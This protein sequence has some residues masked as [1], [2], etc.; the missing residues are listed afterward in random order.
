MWQEMLAL[1]RYMSYYELLT[2]RYSF[3]NR[4]VR[5]FLVAGATLAVGSAI[6]S[7]HWLVGVSGAVL[8]VAATTV[9]LVWDW[10]TRAALAHAISLECAVIS[11]DY[12]HLWS[13]VET[14]R[15]DEDTCH[16]RIHQLSMRAIAAASQL[17]DT[18]RTL[19]KQAQRAAYKIL[20]NKWGDSS[21]RRTETVRT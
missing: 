20:E 2:N 1:A 8:L 15:I 12:D 9:D 14:K 7:V 19:N 11:K 6:P 5:A 4:L 3:R 18:D 17:A 10:S 16:L 13:Q 21:G